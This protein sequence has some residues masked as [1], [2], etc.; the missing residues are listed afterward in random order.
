[1]QILK[2]KKFLKLLDCHHRH[3]RGGG[4]ARTP[5][6]TLKIWIIK[7]NKTQKHVSPIF[8]QPQVPPF[9]NLKITVR[10]LL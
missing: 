2:I 8:S 9:E 5:Q 4:G 6:K 10:L 7:I 1:M 3:T